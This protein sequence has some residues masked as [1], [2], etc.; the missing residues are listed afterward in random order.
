[1]LNW[2]EFIDLRGGA[3]CRF[4]VGLRLAFVLKTAIYN[5]PKLVLFETHISA[6]MVWL[7][8]AK[9]VCTVDLGTIPLLVVR[10]ECCVIFSL[11][12]S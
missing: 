12:K 4:G 6:D 7:R 3:E 8:L 1:M 5:V 9:K 2:S 10:P 11:K